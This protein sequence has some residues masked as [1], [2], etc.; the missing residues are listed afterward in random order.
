MLNGEIMQFPVA[1]MIGILKKSEEY[2]ALWY[3]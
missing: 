2:N 3:D 1:E